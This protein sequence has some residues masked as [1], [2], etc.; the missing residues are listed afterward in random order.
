MCNYIYHGRAGLAEPCAIPLI[1][2]TL[3]ISH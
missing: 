3:E 2:N 1:I